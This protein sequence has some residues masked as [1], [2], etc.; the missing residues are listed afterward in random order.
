[1]SRKNRRKQAEQDHKHDEPI[2]QD[3]KAF[4]WHNEKGYK[5]KIIERILGNSQSGF[6]KA[7]QKWLDEQRKNAA[8]NAFKRKDSENN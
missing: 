5:G 3:T 2:E 8:K 1:M 6:A 4:I 7:H